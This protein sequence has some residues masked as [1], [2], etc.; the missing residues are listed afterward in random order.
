MPLAIDVVNVAGEGGG[1]LLQ[2][3]W[4][5]GLEKGEGGGEER[6]FHEDECL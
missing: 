6:R 1:Q 2:E 5:E 3:A 4:T